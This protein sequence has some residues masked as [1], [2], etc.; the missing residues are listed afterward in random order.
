MIA[1]TTSGNLNRIME[2]KKLYLYLANKTILSLFLISTIFFISIIMIM[3]IHPAYPQASGNNQLPNIFATTPDAAAPHQ[4]PLKVIII[5]Q[6]S[7][8]SQVTGFTIVFTNVI[9]IPQNGSMIIISAAQDPSFQ[10]TNAKLKNTANV[11]FDQPLTAQNTFS[12]QGI[13]TGVYTLDVIGQQGNIHGAYETILVI[14][15]P[16][17][18]ITEQT[19]KVIQQRIEYEIVR[20]GPILIDPGCDS[21]TNMTCDDDGGNITRDPDEN[22]TEDPIICTLNISY[23]Q[24]PCDEYYIPPNESGEC[25][26]RHRFVDKMTGC[27]PTYDA[28]PTPPTPR[29]PVKDLPCDEPGHELVNGECLDLRDDADVPSDDENPPSHS[30]FYNNGI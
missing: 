7:E 27:V 16:N 28:L 4:I 1:K 10:I 21:Y 25:P 20:V 15:A 5:R 3:T 11:F 2:D 14:L 6:G 19:R 13:P 24:G 22:M 8:I 18:P 17:Q 30:I 12:L 9:Q 26:E 23:G 29:P